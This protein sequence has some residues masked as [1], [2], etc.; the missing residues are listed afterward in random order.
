MP[1]GVCLRAFQYQAGSSDRRWRARQLDL[2]GPR[3]CFSVL[4]Q[5]DRDDHGKDLDIRAVEGRWKV[6][7]P[8]RYAAGRHDGRVEVAPRVVL[9]ARKPV[10]SGG[11][12][13]QRAQGPHR[14]R[15]RCIRARVQ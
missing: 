7:G 5:A 9:A 3:D 4:V 8:G 12:E 14:Q 1:V 2:A 11:F 10:S 15:G 6:S 13:L